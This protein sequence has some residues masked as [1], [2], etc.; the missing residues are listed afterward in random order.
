MQ[1]EREKTKEKKNNTVRKIKDVTKIKAEKEIIIKNWGT[2]KRS[3][4]FKCH[5]CWK[6]EN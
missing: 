4:K 5:Y 2:R 1:G 3:W 6:N